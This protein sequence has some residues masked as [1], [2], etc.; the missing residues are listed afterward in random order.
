MAGKEYTVLAKYMEYNKQFQEGAW[1][2]TADFD[3]AVTALGMGPMTVDGAMEGVMADAV[4]AQ[5]AMNMKMDMQKFLD[6]LSA[7][8]GQESEMTADELAL[9]EALKTDGIGL[10]MRMDMGEGMVYMTLTGEALETMGLPA[11]TWYSMDMAAMFDQLGMDYAELMDMS[12]TMDAAA[13]LETMLQSAQ[14]TDKDTAYATVAGLV[15][16]A[17]GLLSDEGFQ[18]DGNNYVTSY[19]YAEDGADMTITFTLNTKNDK[20]V[21]YAMDMKMSM[22]T[23][24]E[25]GETAEIMSMVMGMDEKNHMTAEIKMDMLGLMSMNMT[26]SGDYKS[27]TETPETEPPADATVIPF[28]EMTTGSG[29]AVPVPAEPAA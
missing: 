8:A 9:L 2:V 21:G 17:A 10:E 26:M 28:E 14:L 11:D 19:T 29:E 24:V 16:T 12:K 13:M 3:A 5:F 15:D 4:K 23:D 18:K 22:V 27:T 25:T 6:D 7:M 20:V 1:A